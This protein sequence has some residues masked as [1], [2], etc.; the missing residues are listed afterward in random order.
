MDRKTFMRELEYLLQDISEEERHE[1]LEYYESYFDEAG[2]DREK[3]VIDE[4][5][6]PSQVAAIIKDGLKG[7]FDNHIESGNDG[8]FN[9]DYQR[10]YEVAG[11][12]KQSSQ[13]HNIFMKLKEKWQ[14]LDR[15]DKFILILIFVIACIPVSSLFAGI[16]GGLVGLAFAFA[17]LF[18]CLWIITFILYF[19][20]ILLMVTGILQLFHIFASGL[21][22][23]GAGLIILALAQAF[24]KFAHVFYKKWIP[25]IID[26]LS[27][28][29]YRVAG[30]EGIQA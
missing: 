30:K 5:G 20:A 21:I 7:Q 29:F 19:I 25:Q 6:D 15:K 4:L 2:I 28:L 16:S 23:L 13:F 18:F 14:E 26:V 1:A 10:N 11:A 22:I 17:G 12:Q 24:G 27:R 3:E 8:F 9:R